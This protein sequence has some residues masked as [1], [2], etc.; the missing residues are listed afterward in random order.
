MPTRP[1]LP[2]TTTRRPPEPIRPVPAARPGVSLLSTR[3]R[4]RRYRDGL[5]GRKQA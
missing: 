2:A 4:R 3:A 1:V 5:P